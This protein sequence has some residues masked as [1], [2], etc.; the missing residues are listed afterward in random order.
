M[1]MARETR[2]SLA[3]I[4]ETTPKNIRDLTFGDFKNLDNELIE[5]GIRLTEIY[6]R[7]LNKVRM[8]P[9]KLRDLLQKKEISESPWGK[10]NLSR[11]RYLHLFKREGI[12][13]V[14]RYLF[15]E[16]YTRGN[17]HAFQSQ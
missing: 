1:E 7:T 2:T 12:D 5:D 9:A 4:L 17:N 11:K 15:P 3:K 13:A 6:S 10:E 8:K 14:H 16:P